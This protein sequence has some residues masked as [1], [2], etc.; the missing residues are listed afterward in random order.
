[1]TTPAYDAVRRFCDRASTARSGWVLR[2][3]QA[4]DRRRHEI[5]GE[6]HGALRLGVRPP[7]RLYNYVAGV[8]Q[9]PRGEQRSE[10]EIEPGAQ[11]E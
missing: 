5:L 4:G 3:L 1:V 11:G 9:E 7:A 8:D 10:N 6:P 2:G